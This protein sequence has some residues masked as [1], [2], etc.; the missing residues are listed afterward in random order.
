[1][2][3]AC[4]N[5][6]NEINALKKSL[7]S[8]LPYVDKVIAID[9]AYRGYPAPKYNSTDRS[10]NY[11]SSF[12]K[13]EVRSPKSFWKDQITKRSEFFKHA[14]PGDFLFIIDADEIVEDARGL[15]NLPVDL[16]V[17]LVTIKS[18]IYRNPYGEPRILKYR[19][20]LRYHQRHHWIFD[21]DS[22][23]CSHQEV[24]PGLISERLPIIIKHKRN[25]GKSPQELHRKNMYRQKQKVKEG[26]YG[27]ASI[28]PLKIASITSFDPAGISHNLSEA[29]TSTTPHKMISYRASNNYIKYPTHKKLANLKSVEE[30]DI[31]H[32]HMGLRLY[33]GRFKR[34]LNQRLVSHHHGT[35]YR[36]SPSDHDTLD[37]KMRAIRLA[38]TLELTKYAPDLTWLPNPI[39]AAKYRKMTKGRER[40]GK[41]R[42]CHS[43]TSKGFKGTEQLK[44]A[45]SNL[46]AKGLPIE[47]VFVWR[48]SHAECL[49]I[50]STCDIT[51]D[52]F[53]LGIQV[54]G[55]EAAAMGQPVIA[56]DKEVANLYKAHLGYV[57]YIFADTQQKIED[58]IEKLVRDEEHFE[59][60]RK[61]IQDYVF[62]RHDYGPV[63]SSY[64]KILGAGPI[65]GTGPSLPVQKLVSKK[66]GVRY[67]VLARVVNPIDGKLIF[68]KD[69]I[70]SNEELEEAKYLMSGMDYKKKKEEEKMGQEWYIVKV[71][72]IDPKTGLLLHGT[73]KRIPL[74]EAVR[75]KKEGVKGLD[76]VKLPKGEAKKVSRQ[77]KVAQPKERK[78]KPQHNIKQGGKT[79]T[80]WPCKNCG[81]NFV[82][83]S[84]AG[85]A[86][87]MRKHG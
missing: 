69:R 86:A 44:K 38:S 53:W 2:L 11:L 59:N 75:L 67:K 28:Q 42:I 64:M 14:K 6:Y 1:M 10:V 52:S 19:K 29:V 8:Y 36:R 65:L 39:P 22:L 25:L 61:R 32:V 60:E 58:Q 57:P 16:D 80:T 77:T 66:H 84:K 56:G 45:V 26:V 35:M 82:A 74:T 34:P 27:M 41:F 9:G 71:R 24:G 72:L 3:I 55:L 73:S 76:D 33:T 46:K 7:K 62:K 31:V 40:K 43:P 78:L 17:G 21:G 81:C 5:F 15:K 20:G 83:K 85:L 54:S 37:R 4:L 70:I 23:F 47:L 50:K 68:G 13:V 49:K 63:A 51:F 30:F 18:P 12:K 79:T 48:K 87:H